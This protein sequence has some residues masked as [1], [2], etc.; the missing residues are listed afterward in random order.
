MTR[1]YVCVITLLAAFAVMSCLCSPAAAQGAGGPSLGELEDLA[2]DL[3]MNPATC[4][5]VQKQIDEVMAVYQSGLSDEQ[6]IA[7]L[8]QLW[9]QTATSM[10]KSGEADSEVAATGNQ[11]LLMMNELVAMA[12]HSSGGSN[13]NVSA[14]AMNSLRKLKALTQNYVKMMKVMCPKLVLPP[15]MNQ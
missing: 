6:K 10:R 7:S 5:A 11:Y 13:K 15:I 8:S 2:K 9:S 14:E 4:D 1:I 3:G 12:K